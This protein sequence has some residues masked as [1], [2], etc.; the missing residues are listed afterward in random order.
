MY[1]CRTDVTEVQGTGMKVVHNLQKF[2]ARVIPRVWLC[3]SPTEHN[4]FTCRSSGYGYGSL[5]KF[6]GVPGTGMEV[7]QN[8]QKFT[9]GL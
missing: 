4:V 5:T 1:E 2:R 7:S 8:Q 6:T 3:T 9:V